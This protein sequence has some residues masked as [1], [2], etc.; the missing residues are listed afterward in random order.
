[1]FVA[2]WCNPAAAQ[3]G[4]D[5]SRG[6][7]RFAGADSAV[8]VPEGSG[9]SASGVWPDALPNHDG[10]VRPAQHAAVNTAAP[11]AGRT[12][13]GGRRIT[14]YTRSS[15]PV[16]FEWRRDPRSNQWMAVID[17]GVNLIVEG[18]TGVGVGPIEVSMIDVSTDRLVLWTSGIE[19]PDLTGQ[20]P[21]ADDVPLEIYMEGNIVFREGERVTYAERMYYDVNNRIGIV[22]D[23]EMLTPVPD[24][25]GLMRI[26]SEVLQQTGRDRFFARN[27]FITS[28]RMGRPGYRIQTADTYVEDDQRPLFDPFSGAPLVDPVTGEPLVEH[29]R[30]ATGRNSL[31]YLGE[32][33]VFYWPILATDLDEPS[34][35]IRRARVRNDRVFGTQ[36][37][38]NWD[39]YQLLGIRNQP[40]GTDW[41]ISFDYLSDRGLGHGTTFTYGRGDFMGIGGPASG[42]FDFWGIQDDGLDNLG[43]ARR[44]VLPDKGYRYRLLWRHRHLLPYDLALS[45]EV[46]WISDR[47]FLEQYY[48][49]EWDELKD[50]T[51]GVELKQVRA[52]TSWSVTAD[53]RLNE[54]FTQT[55]WLPRA[56]LHPDGLASPGRSFLAG[57]AAVGRPVHLVRALPRGLRPIQRN[58]KADPGPDVAAVGERRAGC[59]LGSPRRANRYPPGASESLPAR[60][61]MCRCSWD[62]SRW[63]PMPWASW[64]TGA[65]I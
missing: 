30:L 60:K 39:G 23:A 29:H 43:R 47:N 25:E 9:Q 8:V 37:L 63:F 4:L 7:F 15:V 34:F 52:N 59:P 32:F 42:L 24:Y 53:Y 14:V 56:D 12:S 54:F 57:P 49:R 22:L 41:D 20:R 64:P 48:E 44:N 45:A 31:L 18:L 1:V 65:R 3:V 13:T 46:G 5:S 16:Q 17:Q 28:S 33:P 10:Q 26:K 35:Y 27:S 40:E 2:C 38:T 55:D 11:G 6:G 62:R 19:E 36:V 61:S 50:Q 51:T 58:R 21:L